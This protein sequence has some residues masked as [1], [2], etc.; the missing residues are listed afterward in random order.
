MPICEGDEAVMIVLRTAKVF[1]RSGRGEFFGFYAM[2]YSAYV[3]SYRGAY[4]DYG[5]IADAPSYSDKTDTHFILYFH[6]DAW[7]EAVQ[8]CP[9]EDGR[10]VFLE[11]LFC[12]K[13]KEEPLFWQFFSVTGFMLTSGVPLVAHHRTLQWDGRWF[14]DMEKLHALR[15]KHLERLRVQYEQNKADGWYEEVEA[16]PTP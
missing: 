16:A 6:A 1:K 10:R 13:F 15:T 5:N 11:D 4:A 14:P 8:S 2:D 3:D 12:G 9:I 7:D